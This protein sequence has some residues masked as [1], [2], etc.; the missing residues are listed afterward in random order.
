M[1]NIM[2][3]IIAIIGSG[4]LNIIVTEII[5]ARNRKNDKQINTEEAS[6]LILRN[7]VRRSAMAYIERGWI[8]DEELEDILAM[9]DCY[10]NRLG[11]NGFLDNIVSKVKKLPVKSSI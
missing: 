2:T 11:G 7:A 3:I 8:Y 10:H 4:L 5:A 9:H 6:K 1:D